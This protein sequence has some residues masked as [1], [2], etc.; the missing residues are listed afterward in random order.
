MCVLIWTLIQFDAHDD[1]DAE[2]GDSMSLSHS[3]LSI[4]TT[5]YVLM[6]KIMIETCSGSINIEH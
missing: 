1:D 3:Q 2:D 6:D 4:S 5:R